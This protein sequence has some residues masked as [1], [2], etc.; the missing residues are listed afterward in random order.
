MFFVISFLH[1]STICFPVEI[2]CKYFIIIYLFIS[3]YKPVA[4]HSAVLNFN[5]S[6]VLLA[7]STH[8]DPSVSRT[9]NLVA[10]TA[11]TSQAGLHYLHVLLKVLSNIKTT[12]LPIQIFR[13]L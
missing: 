1:I 12:L 13:Q 3:V 9:A 10:Q 5:V 8:S 2:W 11:Q 4:V 7:L 6:W